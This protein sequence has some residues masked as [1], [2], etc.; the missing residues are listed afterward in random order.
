MSVRRRSRI[1]ALENAARGYL[2]LTRLRTSATPQ[3]VTIKPAIEHNVAMPLYVSNTVRLRR[4]TET[5]I[6]RPIKAVLG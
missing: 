4:V 6:A 3:T 1:A 2:G 5:N